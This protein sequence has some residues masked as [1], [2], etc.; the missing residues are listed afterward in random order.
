M[1]ERIEHRAEAV[2]FRRNGSRIH[3]FSVKGDLSM[4]SLDRVLECGKIGESIRKRHVRRDSFRGESLEQDRDRP[5]S[6][7][8]QVNDLRGAGE[9]Q[10]SG[11]QRHDGTMQRKPGLQ[12]MHVI[13]GQITNRGGEPRL[14]LQLE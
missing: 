1:M 10:C 12:E 6:T 11:Y 7:R 5:A 4:R 2:Q 14:I 3:W 9:A 8:A 13:R